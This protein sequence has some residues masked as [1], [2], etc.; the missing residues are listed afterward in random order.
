MI[1]KDQD[2]NIQNQKGEVKIHL[3]LYYNAQERYD[4]KLRGNVQR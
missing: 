1:I 2:I 4:R 3:E